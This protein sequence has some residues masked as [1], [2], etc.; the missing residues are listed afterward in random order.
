MGCLS[1]AGLPPALNSPVPSETKVLNEE[2]N[3]VFPARAQA[4]AAG[5][6]G[7]RTTEFEKDTE[8]SKKTHGM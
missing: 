6:G 4:L 7:E 5:S 3:T 1:I 8:I 2:H